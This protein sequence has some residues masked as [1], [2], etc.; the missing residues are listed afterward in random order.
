LKQLPKTLSGGEKQ[1][2][3]LARALINDPQVI[4]ADEPTGS[5][6]SY[7]EQVILE[8]FRRIHQQRPNITIILV[9]HSNS[10]IR[11][12][13]RIVQIADG[14]I[15]KDAPG[16]QAEAMRATAEVIPS[17]NQA[18]QASTPQHPPAEAGTSSAEQHRAPEAVA[19][20]TP[21]P[22]RRPDAPNKHR[23]E[24]QEQD[25]EKDVDQSLEDTNRQ[26]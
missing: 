17:G 5:L 4:L 12:C 18:P 6:D 7:N 14:K 3:A 8:L 23:Y 22:Q 2:V 20:A 25:I 13:S 15:I 1:R 26:R 16:L 21:E 24:H 10:V 11:H 9:T 19:G